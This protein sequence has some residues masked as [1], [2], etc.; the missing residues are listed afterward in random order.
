MKY[1]SRII[2]FILILTCVSNTLAID[3]LEKA[4]NLLAENKF[5]EAK[6]LLE[7]FIDKDEN[8]HEAFFLLGKVLMRMNE[9]E[10]ASDNFE[11]A[12]ELDETNAEYHFSLGQ[13]YGLDARESNLISQAFLAPKIKSE[14]ERTIELDP[15]HIGGRSGLIN[16][17]IQAPGIMGGD[18]E[19]ARYHANILINQNEFRGRILLAQIYVQEEKA[20]SAEIQFETLITNFSDSSNIAFIY[21][22]YGYLLLSL[23]KAEKA[24]DIFKKQVELIPD[25][26]NSY[27]SL[28]DGFKAAGKYEEAVEQYCKALEINPD[29][30]ASRD[31]L[32]EVEELLKEKSSNLIK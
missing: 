4:E 12:V 2:V 31:N 15:D 16:Y 13:A 6:N 22:S 5:E 8:N 24:I 27:D 21:N 10:D 26:A 1:L 20:D 23:N 32:E 18:I 25:N 28:G 17:L 29:F 7:D 30:K 9:F 11:E 14:F 19:E 3:D